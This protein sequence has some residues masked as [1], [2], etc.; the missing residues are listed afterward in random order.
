MST[1]PNTGLILSPPGPLQ[2]DLIVN[3]LIKRLGAVGGNTAPVIDNDLSAPPTLNSTT[4]VGKTYIIASAPTGVWTDRA[5]QVAYWNGLA[6][7][8]YVPLEGW[9]LWVA[10]EDSDFVFNGTNWIAD[11]TGPFQG[12][13]LTLALNEAKFADIASA[14]TTDIGAAAGNFGHITGTTT[15]TALGTA[16]AGTRRKTV[17]DGILTLTH[18][19]TS[20]I[21]ITGANI[22]TAAGDVAEWESEGS[23]NWRMTDYSRKDGTS[24]GGAPGSVS[25]V[26]GQTGIAVVLVP[27]IVACSDETTALTTGTAKVTFRMPYAME[28]TEPPRASVTTAPTGSVLT[29]DINA[30]GSSILSTKITIDAGEKTSTTAAT[31]PVLSDT[32]LADDEEI[33]I[34]IDTVGSSTAGMGLKVALIGYPA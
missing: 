21:L 23:G 3:P 11:A 22:T 7:E 4:D 30:S 29:V 12:G 15:I 1:E 24:L 31:P 9:R 34:D 20:M 16:Q 14:A 26:N 2:T 17:F 25:S 32:T 18:N 8:F 33:T 6:W 13:N 28:L 10:D 19:A 27:I 5:N